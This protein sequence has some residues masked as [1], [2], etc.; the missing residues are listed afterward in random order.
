MPLLEHTA[1]AVQLYTPVIRFLPVHSLHPE[2][3]H[4]EDFFFIKK[5]VQNSN[6]SIKVSP[7]FF[8]FLTQNNFYALGLIHISSTSDSV[9]ADVSVRSPRNS[10]IFI[11]ENNAYGIKI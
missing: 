2:D 4:P 9:L 6:H 11:I 10:S 1:A 7:I 3:L 8:W 5:T